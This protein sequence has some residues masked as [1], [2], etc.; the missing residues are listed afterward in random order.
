M[1]NVYEYRVLD[2]HH[3][4][5]E[6]KLCVKNMIYNYLIHTSQEIK[7]CVKNMMYNYLII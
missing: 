6:I 4:S 7:L 5:Q 3:T 1:E 2:S